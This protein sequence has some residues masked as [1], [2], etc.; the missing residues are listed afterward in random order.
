MSES[1]LHLKTHVCHNYVNF[2]V[3]TKKVPSRFSIFFTE[4]PNRSVLKKTPFLQ[5]SARFETENLYKSRSAPGYLA[6]SLFIMV[7]IS[8]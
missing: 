5:S 8:K 1:R 2:M 4:S 6:Y 3:K 7:Y